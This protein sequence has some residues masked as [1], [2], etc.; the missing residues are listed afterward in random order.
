ME[1][2]PEIPVFEA[3]H[4][5]VEDD[6]SRAI[7]DVLGPLL[8]KDLRDEALVRSIFRSN[9]GRTPTGITQS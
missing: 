4:G 9:G 8:S 2:L 1:S 7:T 3:D 5:Y 6:V